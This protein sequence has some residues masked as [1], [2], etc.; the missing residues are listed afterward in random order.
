MTDQPKKKPLARIYFAAKIDKDQ[1]G[2][3][4]LGPL[5]EI[6][7]VWPRKDA[8][9]GNLI[10]FDLDVANM[11]EGVTFEIPYAEKEQS[12]AAMPSEPDADYDAP[13]F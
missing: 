2:Q 9:K 4:L 1:Y 11:R 6:G 12:D 8:S 7:S 3:D 13:A 10:R 5:R